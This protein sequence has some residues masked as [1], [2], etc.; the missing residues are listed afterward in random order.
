MIVTCIAISFTTMY[1]IIAM[2]CHIV[3]TTA[4]AYRGVPGAPRGTGPP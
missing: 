2:I 3:I 1:H 4:V